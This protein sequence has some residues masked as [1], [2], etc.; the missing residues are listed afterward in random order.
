MGGAGGK[1]LGGQQSFTKVNPRRVSFFWAD[2]GR[3]LPYFSAG[4]NPARCR[5]L[6]PFALD[7]IGLSTTK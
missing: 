5:I 1:S 3:G 7:R 6:L 2:L 4:A